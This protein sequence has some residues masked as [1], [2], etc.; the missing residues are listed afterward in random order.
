MKTE[1][2]IHTHKKTF[3]YKLQDHIKQWHRSIS[4]KYNEVITCGFKRY[5]K[6][7]KFYIKIPHA[8]HTDKEIKFIIPQWRQAQIKPKYKYTSLSLLP[9]NWIHP[10]IWHPCSLGCKSQISTF[11]MQCKSLLRLAHRGAQGQRKVINL[12]IISH[13]IFIETYLAP[14]NLLLW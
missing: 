2:Y 7:F 13:I 6:L 5:E 3:D 10:R 9:L 1:Y 14:Q 12:L 8:I 11:Y 4:S